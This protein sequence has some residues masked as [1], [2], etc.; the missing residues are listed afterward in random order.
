M[1]ID[2]DHQL[3]RGSRDELAATLAAHPFTSDLDAPHLELLTDLA[4]LVTVE[5]DRLVL[6]HGQPA[7]TVYLLVEGDVALEL[8]G[9]EQERITLQTLHEGDVLGW[10]W[11]W[12][13]YHWHLDARSLTDVRAIAL[14][15]IGLREALAA[16]PVLG[17]VVTMRIGGVLVDRLRHARE[18]L[19]SSLTA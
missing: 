6:R 7:D 17:C 4:G 14:D 13:P 10:S 11:L 8:A 9:P 18:R 3:D 19:A 16:D 12:P 1:R 2:V 5:A 15:G